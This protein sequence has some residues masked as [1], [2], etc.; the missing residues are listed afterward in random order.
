MS[1]LISTI[2]GFETI[3]EVEDAQG[4]YEGIKTSAADLVVVDLDGKEKE[5]IPQ[6]EDIKKKEK[7]TAFLVISN[8]QSKESVQRLLSIGI[9]GILTKS[10]SE[11]E[12]VN[13]LIAVSKGSR[14]FCNTVLEL[15]VQGEIQEEDC[16]PTKLSAREY[17]VIEN[18]TKGMTTAMIAEKLNLSVHTINSHRKN[19]LK[20]LGLSSPT[21]LVV[22]ALESGLIKK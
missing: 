22:Y 1:S 7:G 6:I 11:E 16:E 2:P 4:L 15:V 17:E 20:K 21:E 13:C 3:L 9:Q 18:I 14:F 12:I 5:L 19:I 10:C 8:M